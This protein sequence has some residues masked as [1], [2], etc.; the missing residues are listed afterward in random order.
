MSTGMS[1]TVLKFFADKDD[2]IISVSVTR[3]HGHP[4]LLYS[5]LPIDIKGL[6]KKGS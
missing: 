1:R 4:G 3:Q 5:R 2:G 6:K